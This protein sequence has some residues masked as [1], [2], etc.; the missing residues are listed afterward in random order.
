M[1]MDISNR[2]MENYIDLWNLI[3]SF[4]VIYRGLRRDGNLQIGPN[5]KDDGQNS[6]GS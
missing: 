1:T 3:I 6:E 5:R 4:P 2:I